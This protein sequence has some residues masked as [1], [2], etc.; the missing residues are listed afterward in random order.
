[1]IDVTPEDSAKM[2]AMNEALVLGSLR[3]HELAQA[4]DHLSQQLYALNAKL[5]R[6][7]AER[8]RSEALLSC[9]K[10]AFEMVAV[11]APL[12][13]V[14]EFLALATERQSPQHLLVAIH[15]LDKSGAR[16][17]QAVAPSLPPGYR[18]VIDGMAIDS[19]IGPCCAAVAQRQRVVVPDIAASKAWPA[20]AAR[21][22]PLGL[23]AAWSEPIFSA[24]GAVL[25]TFVNFCREA[26]EP[27]PQTAALDEIVARTAAIVIERKQAEAT[28]LESEAFSVSVFE[29]N[30]DCIKIIDA[31]GH[32]ERM[33]ANGQC[34]LEID[35]FGA[36]AGTHWPSLWPPEQRA[37][38]E[39]AIAEA[40]AG[41]SGHF[42]GPCATLKGS[43][44]WWD[45]LVTAVPGAAHAPA[46]L[47]ASSRDITQ[48]KRA[49]ERQLFLTREVAHRG[50]NLL[51]VVQSIVARSLT[52]TRPLAEMRDVLAQR[53][54]AL[55]RGLQ[56][57]M[58]DGVEGVSLGETIRSEFDTFSDRIKASGP[59]VMLKP[60]AAQTVA[61]VVHE[62][63]TNAIK[64]GA[65][66]RPQGQVALTWSV[67][68]AGPEARFKFHWQERGG[69][70]VVP[71][72]REG[73]GRMVLETAAAA[74]FGAAP[75]INFAPE[76]LRY[77]LDVLLSDIAVAGTA[78]V[79]PALE[80]L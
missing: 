68:G 75:E 57:L 15:L 5:H 13:E 29:A 59:V 70:P 47:I 58:V 62:L 6:E 37:D 27:D 72:A 63:A 4:S 61:L 31:G 73:F 77:E 79:P 48:R 65:L 14:L 28:L 9:Q 7:I 36:V 8:E 11:G 10:K 52:G 16:F 32:I 26:G 66:S 80:S 19:D 64:Y 23:R 20:F 69:P 40:Q 21:V 25:G 3:Q 18:Q 78:G 43:P 76:G 12:I 44:R 35:D 17:E 67:E 51:A 56:I 38:I 24:S 30:P 41:R 54:Q 1:M 45:V 55:A 33:N 74:A 49:E 22:L 50:G 39:T 53:I 71:P 60:Q 42:S 2:L 46:R 34:L